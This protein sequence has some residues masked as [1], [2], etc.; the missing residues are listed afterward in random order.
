[1]TLAEFMTEPTTSYVDALAGRG[2]SR[3]LVNDL[4][5]N[6]TLEALELIQGRQRAV[7]MLMAIM[8]VAPE[9]FERSID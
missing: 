1:V 6:H 4:R 3:N 7:E 8:L 9:V 2:V 5:E